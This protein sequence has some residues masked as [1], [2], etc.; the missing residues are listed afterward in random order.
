MEHG[1]HSAILTESRQWINISCVI[2]HLSNMTVLCNHNNHLRCATLSQQLVLGG[3]DCRKPDGKF[4]SEDTWK[5]VCTGVSGMNTS[6][7]KT[8][9]QDTYL[10]H[11]GKNT[12]ISLTHLH[13]PILQSTQWLTQISA[14]NYLPVRD[15][16]HLS[17]MNRYR[18][19]GEMNRLS[20]CSI[21]LSLWTL[22]HSLDL[23]AEWL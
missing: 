9:I 8:S 16:R 15:W 11:R 21:A 7:L 13:H 2:S 18:D 5:L 6:V 14:D 23:I 3:L 1:E 12:H 19:G 17:F 22:H 20:T 4:E 10:L